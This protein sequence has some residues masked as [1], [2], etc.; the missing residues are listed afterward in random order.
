MARCRVF[1]GLGFVEIE[2]IL[3]TGELG[4]VLQ[5]VLMVELTAAVETLQRCAG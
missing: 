5:E 2:G 4:L 1:E 3:E